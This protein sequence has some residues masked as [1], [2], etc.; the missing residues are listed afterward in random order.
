M[1]RVTILIVLALS[2]VISFTA[3][4]AQGEHATSEEMV[5]IDVESAAT[6]INSIN[7]SSADSIEQKI[8]GRNEIGLRFFAF[9]SVH[10]AFSRPYES[11]CPE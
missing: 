7:G 4:C 1:N 6:D 10:S 11:G 8:A 2:A 3:S 5:M 9:A